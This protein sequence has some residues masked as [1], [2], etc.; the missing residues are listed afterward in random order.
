MV[1]N[2]LLSAGS[3]RGRSGSGAIL[4]AFLLALP[5]PASAAESICFGRPG[6]GRL[7]GGVAL[8]LGGA[9]FTAYS[10]LASVL[11]RNYVHSRVADAI[12]EA[13]AGL[14]A[15]RKDLVFVYGESGHAGGGP[16]PPHRTHQNGLSAD[17]M[18]PVRDAGGTSVALPTHP[19]NRYG[20]GIE[21][22]RDGRSGGY[23]IDFDAVAL[24]LGALHR[25]ARRRGLGIERVIFDPDYLPRLF[26]TS[27]GAYL[28][29]HIPFMQRQA[30]VRHDEHYHVDFALPCRPLR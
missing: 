2:D 28:Q 17:F 20:Y 6:K 16:F 24:H 3:P 23:R 5:V 12:V 13:Y 21:F 10:R 8:P 9:N 27:R 22:D 4:C 15:D 19:T 30:W 14:A 25:S 26:A 18:V 1:K 29:A 7:E 11:D